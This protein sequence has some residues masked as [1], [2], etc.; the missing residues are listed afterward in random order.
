MNDEISQF[1]KTTEFQQIVTKTDIE[2]LDL[3]FD[4]KKIIGTSVKVLRTG[5][6][7]PEEGWKIAEVHFESNTGKTGQPKV[8]VRKSY[9]DKPGGLEKIVRWQMLEKINPEIKFLFFEIDKDYVLFV[10]EHLN[11]QIG[12]VSEVNFEEESLQVIL[13]PKKK[14]DTA[15]IDKVDIANLLDKNNDPKKLEE[16]V[17]YEVKKRKEASEQ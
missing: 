9:K 13:S 1:L 16:I 15:S 2:T 11:F 14:E 12:L 17:E 7:N 5:K 4:R 10:D 6:P 3:A 8:T